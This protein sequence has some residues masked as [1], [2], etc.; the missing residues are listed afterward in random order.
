MADEFDP[1]NL[2]S[3]LADDVDVTF[4]DT[5]FGTDAEYNEGKTLLLISTGKTDDAEVEGGEMRLMYPCGNGWETTDKGKTAVREDGKQK[6]FIKTSGIGLLI[7]HAIEA[8]CDLRTVGQEKGVTPFEAALWD[9]LSF[10][11]KRKQIKYGGEIGT[12]ERLLPDSF[13]ASGGGSKKSAPKPE[14]KSEP[15]GE[16]E[17]SGDEAPANGALSAAEKAK[18]KVLAKKCGT[19]DEFIEKAFTELEFVN[20]NSAAEDAVMDPDGIY[21]EANA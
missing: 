12:V 20:N 19:H 9:G 18:L 4:T 10:H 7:T 6:N 11:M 8:G 1:F 21:A 13:I 14:P 3:G 15:K 2:G 17:S 5:Y 16:P